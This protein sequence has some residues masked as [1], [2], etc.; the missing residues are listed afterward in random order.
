MKCLVCKSLKFDVLTIKFRYCEK[1]TKLKKKSHFFKNYL[2][3]LK[4]CV[5]F[6]KKFRPSKNTWTL[7]V[8]VSDAPNLW[9]V[10][11]RYCEKDT[12]LEKK[13]HF[14]LKLLCTIIRFFQIFV[15]FTQY[16]NFPYVIDS[17]GASETEKK[18]SSNN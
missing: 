17:G 14:A 1:A 7:Y 8:I 13:I 4:Q 15:A 3:T 2:V 16:L 12:K 18:N 9:Y 10:K 11:F 6:L 5:R